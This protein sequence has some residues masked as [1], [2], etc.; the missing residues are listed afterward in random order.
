M[1][2]GGFTGI[3]MLMPYSLCSVLTV[4]NYVNV[5]GSTLLN[6][7][8]TFEIIGCGRGYTYACSNLLTNGHSYC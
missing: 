5:K 2:H 4:V 6:M 1:V 7:I 3:D 8:G